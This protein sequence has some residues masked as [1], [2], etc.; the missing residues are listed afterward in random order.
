MERAACPRS[1]GPSPLPDL[2]SCEVHDAT[3][4][5]FLVRHTLLQREEE[6]K[7]RKAEEKEKEKEEPE[8]K[9]RHRQ[10]LKREFLALV[11]LSSPLTPLQSARMQELADILGSDE[12]PAVASG[13]RRK[14]KKRRKRRTRRSQ[15]SCSS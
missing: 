11:D 6:E 14:R 12:Q 3:L 5:A 7:K 4:V 1:T 15:F 13:A 10:A 2:G 9:R 8:R